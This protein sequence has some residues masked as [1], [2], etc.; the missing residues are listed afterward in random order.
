MSESQE[1]LLS[2]EGLDITE[3]KIPFGLCSL[4]NFCS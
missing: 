2:E 1:I 3:D 4:S